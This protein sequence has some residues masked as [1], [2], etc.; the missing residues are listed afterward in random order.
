MLSRKVLSIMEG[1]QSS[2]ED[3][4]LINRDGK[5]KLTAS[6]RVSGF[7]SCDLPTLSDDDLS[8]HHHG[9]SERSWTGLSAVECD[10]RTG[11][12]REVALPSAVAF[13]NNIGELFAK[14][15]SPGASHDVLPPAAVMPM[16]E[17]EFPP[18]ASR[19][20]TPYML[21]PKI[22]SRDMLLAMRP[23]TSQVEPV[24]WSTVSKSILAPTPKSIA[25]APSSP[26]VRKNA[27]TPAMPRATARMSHAAPPGLTRQLL[28]LPSRAA[29]ESALECTPK[30]EAPPA[31]SLAIPKF[32]PDWRP[33]SSLGDDSSACSEGESETDT[34]L[35]GPTPFACAPKKMQELWLPVNSSGTESQ[36]VR[37]NSDKVSL[38]DIQRLQTA[39]ATTDRT[40]PLSFGSVVH[41][42]GFRGNCRPCMFERVA[43][44]CKKIWLCDFCHL[45]AG[46]GHQVRTIPPP[47]TMQT[48]TRFSI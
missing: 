37:S 2:Y 1:A 9:Q 29:F 46:R 32:L 25:R 3:L 6:T 28:A 23:N 21:D 16:P 22:I 8:S 36:M 12:P 13:L 17:L 40:Q 42:C 20:E 7:L 26:S 45:H 4:P 47:G 48:I 38:L 34:F 19:A 35:V 5:K 33:T 11:E 43:G 41:L 31:I 30:I 15:E 27:N 39:V 18:C 24:I 44:R 14:G 10:A